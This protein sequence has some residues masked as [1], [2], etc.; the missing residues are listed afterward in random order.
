VKTKTIP[1]VNLSLDPLGNLMR[2]D[3]HHTLHE[4]G[5]TF[6]GTTIAS[7]VLKAGKDFDKHFTYIGPVTWDKIECYYIEVNFP[8]YHYYTYTTGKNE[9]VTSIATKLN[10]PDFKIRYKNELSSYFGA[11]KEGKKLLIPNVYSKRTLLY[12]DKKTNLPLCIKVYDEDGLYE[13]YE[14]Y[15]MKA[16]GSFAIDEFSKSFKGYGF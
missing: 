10:A 1:F 13:S 6:V 2:K 3:Q 5:Y 9:T 8:D 15:N 16:N 4:L 14:M 7:G 12:I 11:I